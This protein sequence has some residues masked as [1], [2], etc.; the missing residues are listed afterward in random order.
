MVLEKKSFE[1][2]QLE[3]HVISQANSIFFVIKTLWYSIYFD[4][5]K[6]KLFLWYIIGRN[7]CKVNSFAQAPTEWKIKHRESNEMNSSGTV[8]KNNVK[9]SIKLFHLTQ[10]WIFAH[11]LVISSALRRKREFKIQQKAFKDFFGVSYAKSL[12]L[13]LAV[14]N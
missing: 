10:P 14:A 12:L 1:L 6:K 13:E 9:I 7:C 11:L 3:F 4:R 2:L 5:R 8:D